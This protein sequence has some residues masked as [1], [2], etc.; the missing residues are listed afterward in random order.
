MSPEEASGELWRWA[1]SQFDPMVVE[2]FLSG[3]A[4]AEVDADEL[5]LA[6]E[7]SSLTV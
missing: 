7:E 4:E 5:G 2:A 6:A 3:L 1:G